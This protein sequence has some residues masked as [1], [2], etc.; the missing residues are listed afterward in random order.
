MSVMIDSPQTYFAQLVPHRD[1]L[2]VSLE[3]EAAK[4]NIPIVGPIVGEWLY[5]LARIG[6][7]RQILELGTATGYSSIFLGRACRI[8]QGHVLTL[9]FDPGLAR[10]ARKNIAQ[11]GLKDTVEVLTGDALTEMEKMDSLFDM[12]FMDIEKMDYA[13]A[14]PH[15]ERLLKE[16]GLLVA[17]NTA[18]RDADPFNQSVHDHPSW[19]S[20]NLY[21]FLPGHSP[22]QD[23]IC[24]ALRTNE[25][26]KR[27][28]N[29]V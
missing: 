22:E 24:L 12:V 5:L 7:A 23:G 13:R 9:E 27:K 29:R 10:R 26:P 21:L 1:P 19:R 2:L 15:C 18:F 25:P 11:A 4:E 14:L 20:V 16:N 6:N 8:N 17:D 28:K 3:K